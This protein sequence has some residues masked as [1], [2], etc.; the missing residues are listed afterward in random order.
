[1]L[2][3]VEKYWAA[4]TTSQDSPA[5][6]STGGAVD[7]TICKI[8]NGEPLYMGSIF[9][10]ATELAHTDYFEIDGRKPKEID[11]EGAAGKVFRRRGEAKPASALLADD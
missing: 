10:D 3:E 8:R 4:P 6:H 5:P 9:D 11:A 7:L 1:M 2:A